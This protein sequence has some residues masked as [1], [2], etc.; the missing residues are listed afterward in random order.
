MCL[1][2]L[3]GCGF[4]FL[5][6]ISFSSIMFSFACHFSLETDSAFSSGRFH[7]W[8]PLFSVR[9]TTQPDQLCIN[10]PTQ[11]CDTVIL[12]ELLLFLK[13][14]THSFHSNYAGAIQWKRSSLHCQML[15]GFP[16]R[17][18]TCWSK[19]TRGEGRLLCWAWLRWCSARGSAAGPPD[20]RGDDVWGFSPSAGRQRRCF[21]L[22]CPLRE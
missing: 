22:V 17:V 12:K 15:I 13:H 5:Y 16:Q 21:S 19:V 1:Q 10:P 11:A 14:Q 6:M 18:P 3:S 4:H 7:R 8:Y 9:E 2:N 20:W